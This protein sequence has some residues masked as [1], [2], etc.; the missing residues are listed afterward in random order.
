[1]SLEDLPDDIKDELGQKFDLEARIPRKAEFTNFMSLDPGYV[2]AADD[3]SQ[4]LR[5]INLTL[6]KGDEMQEFM[7]PLD[8]AGQMLIKI[9]G[10]MALL[11]PQEDPRKEILINFMNE[12]FTRRK[13]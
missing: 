13:E 7:L 6:A 11:L 3:H 9:M 8:D 12:N 2:V 5:I 10:A 1:M 4:K